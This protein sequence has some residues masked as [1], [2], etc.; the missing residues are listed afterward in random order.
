L[1]QTLIHSFS[2]HLL[3][4]WRSLYDKWSSIPSSQSNHHHHHLH[5]HHHH[6]LDQFMITFLH[7]LFVARS[8]Q[9]R[10]MIQLSFLPFPCC[11]DDLIDLL[12][13][14]FPQILLFLLHS[15]DPLFD[16]GHVINC[17][18]ILTSTGMPSLISLP[19]ISPTIDSLIAQKVIQNGL[20]LI[21]TFPNKENSNKGPLNY[22][23][24]RTL[25]YH[26][27]IPFPDLALDWIKE[28]IESYP[29]LP[30]KWTTL[31]EKISRTKSRLKKRSDIVEETFTLPDGRVWSHCISPDILLI[32]QLL[33]VEEGKKYLGYINCEA[34]L[35]SETL[36]NQSQFPQQTQDQ[37]ILACPFD[38]KMTTILQFLEDR[39]SYLLLEDEQQDSHLIIQC[40][41]FLM[42][43]SEQHPSLF[44]RYQSVIKYFLTKL[45]QS[46]FP[47]KTN[48]LVGNETKF[49]K[50][51]KQNGN[52]SG[53]SMGMVTN[54]SP[55]IPSSSLLPSIL[56]VSTKDQKNQN[57]I[58]KKLFFTATGADMNQNL[59]EG[60]IRAYHCCDPLILYLHATTRQYRMDRVLE[61][62]SEYSERRIVSFF[63]QTFDQSSFG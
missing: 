53:E 17:L 24:L 44:L 22:S 49:Q 56:L 15:R 11:H 35:N 45:P 52:E 55:L 48:T 59:W 63:Q 39:S 20:P 42:I 6:I 47:N 12:E 18:L 40:Q 19:I 57:M 43:L 36:R 58:T 38:Q 32:F 30:T 16:E 37:L 62:L 4:V 25:L 34:F 41:Q 61:I 51:K 7:Y 60:V 46:K 33:M 31:L 23:I 1:T 10:S 54:E 27:Y 8:K 14:S 2:N 26:A 50:G 13:T 9:L 29:P 5:H 21:L 28:W 3:H